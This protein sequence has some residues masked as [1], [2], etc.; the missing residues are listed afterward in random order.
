MTAAA[1]RGPLWTAL[2][3]DVDHDPDRLEHELQALHGRLYRPGDRLY[4]IESVPSGLP[5]LVLR[6][7]EADGEYYVYVED[8]ARGRLAGYTV[9]NRLIELDRR[10]DRHLRAPHSRYAPA[11]PRLGLATAIYRRA[12]ESGLC[13]LS[14]ARQSPGAHALWMALGRDHA[15]GFVDLRDRALRYLGTR[16]DAAAQADLHTR[17]LLLG[18]GWSLAW[19]AARTGMTMDRSCF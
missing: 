16:V 7:R 13:L 17:M 11:Y 8:V 14:G 9:F 2:R 6:C 15:L 12:L 19:L 3:I 1:L 18:Q 10:A 5:G 4:G